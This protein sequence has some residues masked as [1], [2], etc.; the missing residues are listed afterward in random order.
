MVLI[1][2]RLLVVVNWL[3][4]WSIRKTVVLHKLVEALVLLGMLLTERRQTLNVSFRSWNRVES[5]QVE[6][7]TPSQSRGHCHSSIIVL[8]RKSHHVLQAVA[9]H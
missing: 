3:L 4:A 2:Q 6:V 7:K 5:H 9:T 1:R 8:L